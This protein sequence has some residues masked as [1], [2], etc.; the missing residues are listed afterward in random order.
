M[1]R[2]VGVTIL[3]SLQ[4]FYSGF[5]LLFS[6]SILLIKPFRDGLIQASMQMLTSNPQFQEAQS[7]A[8]F[9]QRVIMMGAGAGILF[10]L[11]GL[12]LGYGLLKLKSWAWICTLILQILQIL[13][14]LQGIFAIVGSSS[15]PAISI[16]QQ[17]FQLLISGIIIYYL[18][19]PDV[20]Q[21]FGRQK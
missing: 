19:R 6:I 16:S 3:A 1:S 10:G 21:A 9:M 8:E 15:V 14:G 7:S 20:K 5:G 18:F 13:G 12:L 17:I 11:V 4:F 2:P